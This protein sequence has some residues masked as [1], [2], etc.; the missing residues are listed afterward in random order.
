MT[1]SSCEI[2]PEGGPPLGRFILQRTDH[3]KWYTSGHETPDMLSA[4]NSAQQTNVT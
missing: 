2:S 1:I 4:H 3:S